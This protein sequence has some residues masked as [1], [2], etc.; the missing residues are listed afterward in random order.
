MRFQGALPVVALAL[1]DVFSPPKP[2]VP[3]VWAAENL[4][5][6]DGPRAGSRWDK[7]LTPYIGPIIDE[8]G[9]DSA[10]NIGAVRKSAQTGVSIG[11][12]ALAGAYIDYAPCRIGYALPTIDA[13]QEFN[14]EKLTPAIEQ[15]PILAKKI[16]P[17]VS[18]T[19]AGS[20]TTSKKFAGGSLVLINANSAADL[21]SKTLKVGIADEVDE[22]ADDLDGQGD[23]LD[24]YQARFT[25]HHASGD[26]RFLALSTPTLE[27][28]SKIDRLYRA[29][30][31]RLWYVTCPGCGE[32][33]TFE[34]KHLVSNPT[35]PY[36]AHYVPPCCGVPI[37]HHQKA[38]L[39]REGHFK[40]T[41]PDGLY[42]SWHID[43]LTSLLTTWDKLAEAYWTAKGDERK[44]K[45]F[46][47]LW[48][49]LPYEVRG[50]APDYV[51]LLERREDYREKQIPPLGLL[52]VAGVDVQHKGIWVEV[53]AY[54]P[55]RQ[56][57]TVW[58]EFL[59]GDTTDPERGAWTKLTALYDEKFVDA[60]GGSR[61]IDALGV[62][63]GDGGRAHQVY[64]WV[65]GRPRAYAVKGVSGW[66]AP[67]IG[68]P[69]PVDIN[70]RGKKIKKGA[71]LWPVGTWSLKAVWYADLRKEGRKAGQEIDPPGY[72]HFGE[73]LDEFYFRQITA[74]YLAT[75]T[76]RGRSRR[77]WKQS[78]EHN[79]LLDCRIY[80]MAMA[81]YLG[82]TRLTP[83]Q[84]SEIARR[85][86]VPEE[87]SQ[88]DMLAPE[89]VRLAAESRQP[90]NSRR[91]RGVVSKGI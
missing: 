13:L 2:L 3:S 75:E 35:P 59:D 6:P 50:D 60:F 39:V 12:L 5:V 76:F 55:D 1:A 53:V 15:T 52:L 70:Y 57:W 23:P 73:W 16:R 68:T 87:L 86:G 56:S 91:K 88:P 48:L 36:E 65:R 29:G 31:Q 85:R 37:E 8:F 21:R 81:E 14:R 67:A 20:T 19:S 22:W 43:A 66:T 38:T 62:D 90:K 10:H 4:V 9:P 51:R 42:P 11:G 54:A 18:R 58:R 77:V 40:S 89:S 33:I 84:W 7:A 27:G 26:Y 46:W 45:A 49:G 74:E 83:E 61:S 44:E 80:A 25:A 72:C 28:S 64:A 71:K 63:A 41:N 32:E 78:F 30:D 69:T 17:Q 34:F 47:N 24:L 82:L 79:H